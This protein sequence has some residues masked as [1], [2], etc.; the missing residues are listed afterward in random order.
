MQLNR[1]ITRIS[2]SGERARQVTQSSDGF[3]SKRLN[4]HSPP[5]PCRLEL[6]L[7][8]RRSYFLIPIRRPVEETGNFCKAG[9]SILVLTSDRHRAPGLRDAGDWGRYRPGRCPWVRG[10]GQV[11]TMHHLSA[12]LH[13][14]FSRS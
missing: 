10:E 14:D 1:G 11:R 12:V 5:A 13:R 9:A 2:I 6:P 4:S 7:R 8:A 3:Y